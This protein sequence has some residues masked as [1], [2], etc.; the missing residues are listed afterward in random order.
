[1]TEW[2]I[3]RLWNHRAPQAN[4]RKSPGSRNAVMRTKPV[5]SFFIQAFVIRA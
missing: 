5:N 2:G 3:A 1:M 4:Q